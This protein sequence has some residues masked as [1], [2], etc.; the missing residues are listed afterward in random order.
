MNRHH[1]NNQR[2]DANT[3]ATNNTT[4]TTHTDTYQ[5][6]LTQPN[7]NTSPISNTHTGPLHSKWLRLAQLCQDSCFL[8]DTN[9]IVKQGM[10][11]STG[12]LTLW[13]VRAVCTQ[14]EPTGR[15]IIVIVTEKRK[16]R[17][18]KRKR[19]RK[20]TKEENDGREKE[21]G[22]REGEE[23]QGERERERRD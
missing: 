20:G 23:R 18:E 14:R 9:I 6:M 22:T 3:E 1:H 21:E 4:K 10:S 11:Q 19:T 13:Q 17:R 7:T 5:H 2:I 16:K 12:P 8:H 15:V